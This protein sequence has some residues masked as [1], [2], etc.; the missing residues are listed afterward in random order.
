[1]T[2]LNIPGAAEFDSA[3]VAVVGLGISGTAVAGVLKERTNARVS[4]WDSS[5]Q[6]IES[7][8][9]DLGGGIEA[10]C[11]SN[12]TMAETLVAERA[13]IVVIAPGDSRHW[14]GTHCP[15]RFGNRYV[16][17]NRAGLAPA[18]PQRIGGVR[19]LARRHGHKWEDDDGHH[20]SGHVD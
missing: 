9:A 19:S 5:K 20:G 2:G 15:A 17:G 13:D 14:P 7:A 3:Y 12:E 10:R 11:L 1:M 4:L 16:V 18:S 6:S 8:Q